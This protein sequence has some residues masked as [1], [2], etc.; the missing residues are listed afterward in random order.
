MGKSQWGL[1]SKVAARVTSR[2]AILATLGVGAC[3]TAPPSGVAPLLN[4]ARQ[5]EIA[6]YAKNRETYLS[7]VGVVLQTGMDSYGP[8]QLFSRLE[9]MRPMQRGFDT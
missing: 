9:V 6:A 7:A 8:Q 4:E 1:P 2:A 3:A 5:N